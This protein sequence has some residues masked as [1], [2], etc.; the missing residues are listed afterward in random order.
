QHAI[1]ALP[2]VSDGALQE[3][4]LPGPTGERTVLSLYPRGV[5]LCLGPSADAAREQARQA[6]ERGC[7]ALMVCEGI[8]LE[9]GVSG[10]IAPDVLSTLA[11]ID[12]VAFWGTDDDAR[13]LRQALAARPGAIVPLVTA[14]DIRPWCV[15][16]RHVCTDT[17]AA[18][19]NASLIASAN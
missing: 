17:T 9:D 16:E 1:D 11:G 19:G 3:T 6:Q 15:L 7:I 2:A 18:G 14:A 8:R 4:T 10:A 13:R 12:A 5:V